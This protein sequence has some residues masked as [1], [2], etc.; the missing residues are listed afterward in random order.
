MS[1]AWLPYLP[2]HLARAIA[3]RPAALQIGRA[4]RVHA[5]ALFADVSGFTPMSEALAR[6]GRRGAEDLT[7]ILNR[8][9]THMI[10]LLHDHGGIVCKFGGDA[11]TVIFPYHVRA[12]GSVTRRA[13][14]CAHAMQVAMTEYAAIPPG[15]GTFGRAMKIGIARGSLLN[16][17]AGDA[18][19][20]EYILAGGPLDRCADAEHHAGKGE[21]VVDDQLLGDLGAL[22]SVE[23]RDGFSCIGRLLRPAG[24]VPARPLPKISAAAAAVYTRYIHPA[25][26][27][28]IAAGQAGFINEHRQVSVLFV[29]FSGFDYD[30]D[31]QAG[32]R[33]Q[34]Y[35]SG[36]LSG[37]RRPHGAGKLVAMRDKGRKQ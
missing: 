13:V 30:A 8:Y 25:I 11:L 36:V 20:L 35:L 12:R 9:F 14:T 31:P 29:N 32:A 23:Q 26:A 33:L 1:T 27:Q 16:M 4:R 17:T 28:R 37:G 24:R 18:D 10:A 7:L 22:S 19:R 3:V 5:V 21:I 6:T 15:A 2:E 34:A